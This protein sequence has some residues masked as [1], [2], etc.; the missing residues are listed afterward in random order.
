M[1]S[2][3]DRKM[4]LLELIRRYQCSARSDCVPALGGG[5]TFSH[6]QERRVRRRFGK[7]SESHFR[8]RI[9]LS[10]V[11][12]VSSRDARLHSSAFVGRCSYLTHRL[13]HFI[14]SFL[15]IFLAHCIPRE[16]FGQ[17]TALFMRV[18][19]GPPTV[20]ITPNGNYNRNRKIRTKNLRKFEKRLQ[21]R[22]PMRGKRFRSSFTKHNESPAKVI[23]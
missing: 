20:T 13:F 12:E 1:R 7:V 8:S 3:F 19:G 4:K 14:F 11:G 22:A 5:R 17:S 21:F 18:R 9:S 2:E 15:R 10:T 23:V 16:L 6:C